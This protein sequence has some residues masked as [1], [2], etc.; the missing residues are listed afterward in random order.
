MITVRDSLVFYLV[1]F[2]FPSVVWQRVI[3]DGCLGKLSEMYEVK[4]HISH[5][6]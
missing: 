1:F 6:S 5:L 2:V 3:K 4:I